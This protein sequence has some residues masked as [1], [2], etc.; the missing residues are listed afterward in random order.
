VE[1][2]LRLRSRTSSTPSADSP[3][4]PPLPVLLQKPI[5]ALAGLVMLRST[6][7]QVV[8]IKAENS[9]LACLERETCC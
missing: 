7:A 6:L 5:F 4:C 2:E 1:K 8:A 9:G 3:L